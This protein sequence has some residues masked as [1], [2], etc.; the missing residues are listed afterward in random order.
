LITALGQIEHVE[1]AVTMD[2]KAAGNKLY[3]VGTTHA[4]EF[5]G[6]HFNLVNGLTGGAVPT[7][8]PEEALATF[9]AVH[10]A[11]KAGLI[12]SCHDLSEGG[13][14]VAVA[15]MAFAGGIG[16]TLNTDLTPADLFAES[17]SRFVVEVEADKV[18]AFESTV[19]TATQIG[20]TNDSNRLIAGSLIQADLSDL[21]D[22]WQQPLNW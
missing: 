7:V 22:A 1:Q 17:N 10:S 16:V 19:P 18:A 15:E 11:I 2:L 8:N 14:A 12:R 21:K 4:E 5:G 3:L 9:K 20:S 13:L 6:S